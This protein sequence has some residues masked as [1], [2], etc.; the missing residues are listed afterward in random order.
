MFGVCAGMVLLAKIIRRDGQ[1]GPGLIGAIDVTVAP[2]YFEDEGYCFKGEI[3]L[4]GA[5][6]KQQALF[7]RGGFPLL[8]S[9][10]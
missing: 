4:S 1:I 10:F 2:N 9:L 3:G 6:G 5:E 7:I 8:K